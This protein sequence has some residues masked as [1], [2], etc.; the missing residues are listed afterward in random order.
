MSDTGEPAIYCR[1]LIVCRTVW[2]DPNRPDDGFSLGKIVIR[3][4][5]PDGQDFPLLIPR[6]FAYVQAFGTPGEYQLRLRLMRIERDDFGEEFEVQL[7]PDDS[8]LQF[9]VPRP[10]ALSGLTLV[11]ELAVPLDRILLEQAGLYELQLWADGFEEPLA[12]ER[13]EVS[14]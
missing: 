3:L 6:L 2:F 10:T 11:E 5:P 13:F 14:K 7:G 9:S 8:L 4:T 12:G 1:H